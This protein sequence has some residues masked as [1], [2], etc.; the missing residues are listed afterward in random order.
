[1]IAEVQPTGKYTEIFS[2]LASLVMGKAAMKR[3][4]PNLLGPFMSKI[5]RRK[6][7]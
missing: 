3:A 5:S 2:S 7:S 4:R 6:A 1:M